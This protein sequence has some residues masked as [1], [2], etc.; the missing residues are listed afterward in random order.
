MDRWFGAIRTNVPERVHYDLSDI[1]MITL[2]E[3][4]VFLV[5]IVDDL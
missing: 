2:L 4:T 5:Q 3:L 1:S